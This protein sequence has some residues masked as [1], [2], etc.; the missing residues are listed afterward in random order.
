MKVLQKLSRFAYLVQGGKPPETPLFFNH[1][2]LKIMPTER[3]IKR[4]DETR[5]EYQKRYQKWYRA[6]TQKVGII[7]SP[8]ETKKYEAIA[9][10]QGVRVGTVIRQLAEAGYNNTALLPPNLSKRVKELVH[11]LRGIANNINQIARF[12]NRVKELRDEGGLFNYLKK[13]E[14]E[15]KSFIKKT[16]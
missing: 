5:E 6:H 15:V 12:S 14:D 7:L 3:P 10:K 2:S 8:A 9:K 11:I 13:L 4:P 1:I 16:D